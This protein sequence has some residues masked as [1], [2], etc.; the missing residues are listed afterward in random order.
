MDLNTGAEEVGSGLASQDVIGFQ[1]RL[2]DCSD[3]V[4]AKI[5][6]RLI[7]EQILKDSSKVT[8]VSHYRHMP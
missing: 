7:L 2:L 3:I 1:R 6:F 8:N 5:E 4:N